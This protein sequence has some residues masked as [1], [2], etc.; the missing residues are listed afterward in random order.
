MTAADA[1]EWDDLDL[2]EL[3]N[4][5][6]MY[7]RAVAAR[8]DFPGLSQQQNCGGAELQDVFQ[9]TRAAACESS[10][11]VAKRAITLLMRRDVL[12]I[13][14]DP[15]LDAFE[16]INMGSTSQALQE[17]RN[18]SVAALDSW[19]QLLELQ[20]TN[21]RR[22]IDE[23]QEQKS[24]SD[25]ATNQLLL[26]AERLKQD[27][28]RLVQQNNHLKDSLQRLNKMNTALTTELQRVREEA[29]AHTG[30]PHDIFAGDGKI[31]VLEGQDNSLAQLDLHQANEDGWAISAVVPEPSGV[32]PPLLKAQGS[33]ERVIALEATTNPLNSHEDTSTMRRSTG[34]GPAYTRTLTLKQL[35]DVINDI[36]AS[37]GR[38][39][40]RLAKV[41][42]PRET[43]EQHLY[44]YLT[45]KF[46]L[47]PADPGL[48]GQHLRGHPTLLW[49]GR[50]RRPFWKSP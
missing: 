31:R 22:V 10:D 46:G 35:K 17:I 37:K 41:Q 30:R 24:R 15:L 23:K 6:A 3:K 20:E 27:S 33:G 5:Q 14:W 40:Y 29:E 43:M 39:D 13:C 9:R 42:Q 4:A 28:A 36:Y 16:Q 26:A 32:T 2:S 44:L 48:E 45:Q 12:D 34:A 25:K 21:L 18:Y 11:G 8:L 49:S 7:D 38:S 50:G 1:A 47:R 19:Q